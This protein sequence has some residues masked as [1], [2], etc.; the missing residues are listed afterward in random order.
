MIL[1]VGLGNP[2][3]KYE[4]TRHNVGFQVID[5]VIADFNL[6]SLVFKSNINAEISKGEINEKEVIVMKPETF[7]NLSGNSVS[8]VVQFYKIPLNEIIVIHDDI[9][10]LLGKIKIA[11]N[12]GSGGH[13]GIESIIKSTGSK[14]FV[15]LRIGIS[16]EKKPLNT[17]I[18]VLK[19]FKENENE[20]VNESIAKAIE[21][22]KMTIQEGV[23]KAS[24]L[25]NF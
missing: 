8:K 19:K 1:I 24:S 13:K 17:E 25:F 23:S 9:D 6:P 16:P 5:K 4:N 12:K 2:G 22:I 11:T 21:A 14:N 20:I 10:I 3:K 7:M 15:R 18:F